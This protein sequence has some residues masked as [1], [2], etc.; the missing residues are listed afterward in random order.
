M[1]QLH[2]GEGLRQ[3]G[4]SLERACHATCGHPH[5]LGGVNPQGSYTIYEFKVP[6]G[7][8]VMAAQTNPEAIYITLHD[9]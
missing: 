8:K 9:V 4:A 2:P 6:V 5:L 7:E 3:E 1:R